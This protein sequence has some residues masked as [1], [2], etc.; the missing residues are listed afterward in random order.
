MIKLILTGA[1]GRMGQMVVKILPQHKNIKLAGSIDTTAHP[2]MGI[3]TDLAGVVKNA[4]VVVDFTGA[5]PS[6]SN[7]KIAES[8]KKP[9]V[10]AS[11]GHDARQVALIKT[12]SQTIPIVYSPNMSVGVNVLWKLIK[13]AAIIFGKDYKIN[14]VETHHV[15]KKDAPSGTAKKMLE[16]VSEA[17]TTAEVKS[18]REG[19]VVGD[20]T[21]TFAGPYETLSI[22]HRAFSREVFADGA[23]RAAEWIVDKKAGLYDMEDVLGLGA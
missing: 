18:I 10:I 21:I 4:D 2:E 12:A 17:G 19:E 7:L 13:E 9:I 20:H 1:A 6:I 16:V 8:T 14:I 23:L 11:T 3:T 15:H 22:T 5:G